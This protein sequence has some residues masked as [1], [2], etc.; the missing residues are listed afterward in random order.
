M[1]WTEYTT[2]GISEKLEQIRSDLKGKGWDDAILYIYEISSSSL[3]DALMAILNQT[4]LFD[5][6]QEDATYET[7][8]PVVEHGPAT[9]FGGIV[10]AEFSNLQTLLG[11]NDSNSSRLKE[12]RTEVLTECIYEGPE[13]GN[14]LAGTYLDGEFKHLPEVKRIFFRA[15]IPVKFENDDSN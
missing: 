4:T 7:S 2:E 13:K 11:G 8:K 6:G 5:Y 3:E 14:A 12:A 10:K 9:T 15:L 1:D